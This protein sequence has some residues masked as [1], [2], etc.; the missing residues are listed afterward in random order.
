ML[1]TMLTSWYP[2]LRRDRRVFDLEAF[3]DIDLALDPRV[4]PST[5]PPNTPRR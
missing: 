4:N 5:G 1:S 2:V 3:P